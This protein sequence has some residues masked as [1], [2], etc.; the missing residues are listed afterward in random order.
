M[1]VLWE[2]SIGLSAHSF[3][4]HNENTACRAGTL[5]NG[6]I[7]LTLVQIFSEEA[8]LKEARVCSDCVHP[9]VSHAYRLHI[10]QRYLLMCC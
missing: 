10:D 9:Y 8:V 1:V 3:V 6:V 4:W 7:S 2:V 5:L